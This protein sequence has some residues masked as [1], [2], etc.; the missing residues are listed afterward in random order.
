M[1]SIPGM[2]TKSPA[3]QKFL[4]VAGKDPLKRLDNSPRRYLS[5]RDQV[6]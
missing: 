2:G 4:S 1:P 3:E 5:D 6:R